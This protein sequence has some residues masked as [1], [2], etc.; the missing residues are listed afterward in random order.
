M[1]ALNITAASGKAIF[2]VY[3]A[4]AMVNLLYCLW[5]GERE[6]CGQLSL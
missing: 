6:G 4:R 1:D 3:D 2:P 5:L